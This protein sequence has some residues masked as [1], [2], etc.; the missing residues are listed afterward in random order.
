MGFRECLLQANS[1][2]PAMDKHFDTLRFEL[3][4]P[5]EAKE[6]WTTEFHRTGR[7]AVRIYVNDKELNALLV[8]LEDQED[9]TTTP[10]DPADVYGHNGLEL[11]KYLKSKSAASY[12]ASLCCCSDF[13][14]RGPHKFPL[15]LREKSYPLVFTHQKTHQKKIDTIPT[16]RQMCCFLL[17]GECLCPKQRQQCSCP[18]AG[19]K[20]SNML[21]KLA[22]ASSVLVLGSSLLTGCA[23]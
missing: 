14:R 7:K 11:A 20:R 19:T 2:L 12:G 9:G 13:G 4:D 1:F 21:Q 18:S 8:E 16:M 6:K 22:L 3:I 10:T 5:Y 23:Q 15:K 17:A